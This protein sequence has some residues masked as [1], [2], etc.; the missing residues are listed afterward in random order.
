MSLK[1]R[2]SEI[3]DQHTAAA[4]ASLRG[5]RVLNMGPALTELNLAMEVSL[6][7]I[8][9]TPSSGITGVHHGAWLPLP[10]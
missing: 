4:V 3:T 1:S 8:C 6:A 5:Y 7:P 9:D 10:I 2:A